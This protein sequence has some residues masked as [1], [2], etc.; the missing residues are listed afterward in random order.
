MKKANFPKF[1][2]SSFSISILT[3]VLFLF[4]FVVDATADNCPPE[5]PVECG[6]VGNQYKCGPPGTVCC[7]APSDPGD[8]CDVEVDNGLCCGKYCINAQKA[9]CCDDEKGGACLL[10]DI[11]CGKQCYP[12]DKICCNDKVACN[13]SQYCC[14]GVCYSP[15]PEGQDFECREDGGYYVRSSDRTGQQIE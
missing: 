9:T 2:L 10:S 15:A 5:Y 7:G 12:S 6:K 4:V 1:V 11:C 3:I 14:N 8:L 13:P